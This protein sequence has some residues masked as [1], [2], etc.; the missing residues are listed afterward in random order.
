MATDFMVVNVTKDQIITRMAAISNH[1][2]PNK[3]KHESFE[4]AE[5]KPMMQM[6]A[7]L[8]ETQLF[9][10]EPSERGLIYKGSDK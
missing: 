6:S 9:P 5:R 3:S 2:W 7:W 8:K 1:V 4:G 10:K